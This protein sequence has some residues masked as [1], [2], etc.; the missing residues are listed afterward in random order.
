MADISTP[1]KAVTAMEADWDLVDALMGGTK[2]MRNAGETYMPRWPNEEADDHK[3]R[4]AVATLLPVLK[5]TIINHVGRVFSEPS[6]LSD[7]T[8]EPIKAYAH[9]FDMAGN[10][11]DVWAQQFFALGERYGLIHALVD[12][13]KT[14]GAKTV[15]E[16]K[17]S[18]ARP[19]AVIISPRQ[20]I[21]WKS[22]KKGGAEVLTELRIK[23]VITEE[24]GEW[25][26]KEVTQI[27]LLRPGYCGIYRKKADEK[28]DNVWFVHEEWETT[29]K[30]I[31]LITFYTNRTGFMTAEPPMLDLAH[32]NVKHWQSQ[33]DQ[34]TILHVARV[35][36]LSVY[37]LAEGEELTVGASSAMRFE[38]R[39]K[40][41]VE[42]T[43]HTGAS[44]KTGQD[45]L[46]D[47]VEQMRMAGA[48]LLRKENTSTKS[49]D[50]TQHETMQEDSP[51]FTM[52]SSLEDALDNILQ[53]MAEWLGLPDG[54]NI[55]V[56]TELETAGNTFSPQSALAIQA[57]RQGGDIRRIDAVRAYQQIGIIDPD[58]KAE[59][60]IDELINAPDL[61]E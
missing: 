18:G 48:K 37:G 29:A 51:L 21:G 15:A 24:D 57:L 38:D 23:E 44:I 30:R 39:A 46:D 41:G 36:I 55:D 33:S 52:S 2:A 25:G 56:R 1:L 54:G 31:P 6:V 53:Y 59:V 40:H 47:L 20:V 10:Q 8:P 35:P 60:I 50:Q 34:D 13:P 4:L 3:C 16:E 42:Y 45:S 9:D 7:E 58:V 26:E 11:L 61:V 28:G 22:E 27:R 19:Y 49:V 43:E 5:E 14:Q 32:L 12:Y 17:A